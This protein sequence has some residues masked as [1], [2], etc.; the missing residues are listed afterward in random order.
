MPLQEPI[1]DEDC[2]QVAGPFCLRS[3]AR[4][5]RKACPRESVD[6]VNSRGWEFIYPR[7]EH[8]PDDWCRAHACCSYHEERRRVSLRFCP[9]AQTA[10]SK[11][12]YTLKLASISILGGAGIVHR[13]LLDVPSIQATAVLTSTTQTLQGTVIHCSVPRTY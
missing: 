3:L 5:I 6:S 8:S 9:H 1:T 12:H 2:G 11:P 4:K 13:I 7:I 10:L